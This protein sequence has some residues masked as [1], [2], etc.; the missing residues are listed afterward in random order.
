[1]ALGREKPETRPR[2]DRDAPPRSRKGWG[3][4]PSRVSDAQTAEQAA[5]AEPLAHAC[6][7]Q[8]IASISNPSR[9]R[10]PIRAIYVIPENAKRR[11]KVASAA[12]AGCEAL[13]LLRDGELLPAILWTPDLA[14]NLAIDLERRQA[15]VRGLNILSARAMT[16]QRFTQRLRR[17]GFSTAACEHALR[18]ATRLGL[19]DDA[20]LAG[21]VAEGLANRK[22]GVRRI[23][24]KLRA[25]GVHERI[26]KSAAKKAAS[27]RDAHADAEAF[28]RTRLQRM[29]DKL[30]KQAKRRRL[31]GQLARRGFEMD[32]A[33]EIVERLV[34]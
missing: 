19:L 17:M 22:T 33:R 2:F 3:K 30:D 11:V 29:P 25:S 15:L 21:R 5:D 9:G 18:E 12:S 31:F 32:I 6:F 13:G 10:I 1:M 26:A 14:A 27:A 8:P 4:G 34:K 28:A 20:K 23:E 16:T 24:Q 7:G